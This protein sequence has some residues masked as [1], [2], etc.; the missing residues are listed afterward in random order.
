M[1]QELAAINEE[2]IATNAELLNSNHLLQQSNVNLQQFAY[3]ASHDL[4]EPLR[5]IQSFSNL[6]TTPHGESLGDGI[7]YVKRMQAAA[8]RMSEL[9]H[10][11]LS[12]L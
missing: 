10:D 8:R 5:K 9:I 2:Y 6:L 1:N 4:Q 12:F 11:L 7:D 3:V